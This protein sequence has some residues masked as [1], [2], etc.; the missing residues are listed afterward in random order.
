MGRPRS[1]RRR[2]ERH[3]RPHRRPRRARRAGRRGH[4]PRVHLHGDV[5]RRAVGRNGPRGRRRRRARTA[6]PRGRRRG[7]DAAHAGHRARAHRGPARAHGRAARDR[8]ARGRTD[9]GR[10]GPRV[11]LPTRRSARGGPWGRG[12]LRHRRDQAARRR[13]G[14]AHRRPRRRGRGPPP[15]L[16]LP[17]REPRLSRHGEPRHEPARARADGGARPPQ[18]DGVRAPPGAA[19]DDPPPLC[20]GVGRAA[21]H[22]LGASPRRALVPQGPARLARR[23][24]AAGG[25]GRLPRGARHRDAPVLRDRHPRPARLRGHRRIRRAEPAHRRPHARRPH[26]RPP[27]RRGRRPRGDRRDRL[28]HPRPA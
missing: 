28:L 23:A 12:G 13:R 25:A 1:R 6:R 16:R 19:R 18:P 22:P 3:G 24:G 7:G 8:R 20:R 5:G 11:R 2:V 17:R 4:H 14:R 10:R 9:R 27:H 26:A 15:P 21:P